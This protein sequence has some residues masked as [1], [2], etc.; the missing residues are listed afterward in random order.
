M[1]VRTKSIIAASLLLIPFTAIHGQKAIHFDGREE[2]SGPELIPNQFIC[3]FSPGTYAPRNVRAEAVRAAGPEGGRVIHAYTHSIQGFSVRISPEGLARVQANNPNISYCEQDQI[4]RL[5]PM[6]PPPGK[7]P[8]SDDG[9]STPPPEETPWGITRV[10]G[11][12]TT[13]T[14]TAWVIDTGID[15]DHPDLNVDTTRSVSYGRDSDWND[16]NGHGTHVAGTIAA[17]DNDIGVIGVAAGAPVVAVR[18]LERNGSGSYSA[19]IAGV[20]HVAKNA[21]AGDVANM[22]LG[23]SPSQ[24]L[25]DAVLRAAAKGIFFSLAAGN[26]SADANNYSPARVNGDKV[27]TVASIRKDDHWS[28]FSNYGRPPVDYAEP[29]EGVL[30]TWKDGGYNTAS[31]TSMAAPHLAGLL[32]LGSVLTDERNA[33]EDP[34]LDYDYPIGIR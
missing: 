29:G 9:A 8:G 1:R 5:E 30:S 7:G 28:S 11:G 12:I 31:G 16:K 14:P 4:M 34:S 23:G 32:L 13:S 25:D 2:V 26:S 19:V 10:S 17:I 24:L 20:D 33:L 21:A 3:A 18:V 27:Y 22:S 6:A 15:A